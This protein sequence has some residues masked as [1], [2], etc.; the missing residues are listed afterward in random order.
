MQ[1]TIGSPLN[2]TQTPMQDRDIGYLT[3]GSYHPDEFSF[4]LG[5]Y[6]VIQTLD[7]PQYTLQGNCA[8]LFD[9]TL[10][11]NELKTNWQRYGISVNAFGTDTTMPSLTYKRPS[12]AV[13][14]PVRVY[15]NLMPY[16]NLSSRDPYVMAF[17]SPKFPFHSLWV[18]NS[19]RSVVV[20]NGLSD[21]SYDPDVTL[22]PTPLQP[23]TPVMTNMN[24]KLF[25]SIYPE[26]NGGL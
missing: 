11:T 24:G 25:V 15:T 22:S 4:F 16:T 10:F 8:C 23:F 18:I 14:T 6:D 3:D 20:T 21:F 2:L 13:S 7:S 26:T 12:T 19:K 9:S 5:R 1:T 17:Q